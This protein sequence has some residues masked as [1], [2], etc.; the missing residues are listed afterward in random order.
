MNT[1]NVHDLTQEIVEAAVLLL[2]NSSVDIESNFEDF[3]KQI[4]SVD[5]PDDI[6][7]EVVKLFSNNKIIITFDDITALIRGETIKK[8]MK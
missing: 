8:K 7:C 1:L 2:T 4:L 6:I 5:F 3:I